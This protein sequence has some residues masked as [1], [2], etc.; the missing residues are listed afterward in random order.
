MRRAS[1]GLV[2]ALLLAPLWAGCASG[3]RPA[4]QAAATQATAREATATQADQ[5]ATAIPLPAQETVD[6]GAAGRLVS[7]RVDAP[8]QVDGQIEG[9]WAAVEPLAV[10]LTW[11]WEG[12]EHA[13]DAELR[14]VHT[15]E[16][17][18]LLAQWSGERPSG[19]DNTAFNQFTLHWRIPDPA[20]QTLDCTV[21]CH[22]A[23]ADG[24]GRFRYANA[25]TIP[26]G[27]SESLSAA[28]GWDAGTWTLEWSRPLSNDNPFDLQFDDLDRA[29]SFLV[30]VFVRVE[31]RPDPVSGRH[32]LVF[33][34]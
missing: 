6:E 16:A 8:P 7:R 22:T 19:D 1:L 20:A 23:F 9:L 30:K 10:P 25:E 5:T 13:L 12:T 2:A 34:P 33:Q 4:T 17:L 26:P 32:L 3:E 24:Q 21:A 28:G 18:Y 14:A 11:G 31:G 29:Y 27:G 15:D